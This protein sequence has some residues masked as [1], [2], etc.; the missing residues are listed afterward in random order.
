MMLEYPGSDS[1]E[2]DPTT[3]PGC[4]PMVRPQALVRADRLAWLMWDVADFNEQ[5]EFLSQFGMLTHHRDAQHLY[6]RAYG[7]A[8][9]V[10]IGRAAS[11][12]AFRGIGFCVNSREEL[13]CLAAGTGTDIES[14]DR[15]GG[16]EVVRLRDPH[17][18]DVEV[19]WGIEALPNM[20]TRRQP[21]PVNTVD[22]KARINQGQRP[23]LVPAPVLNIGH[24]VLGTDNFADSAQW[25]MRHLGLIPTDVT[26]LADGTPTI[27]FMRL[28]RGDKPADHHTIVISQ[29]LGT[30]YQHSAYEVADID[31]LGQGSQYLQMN[32]RKHSWGIGRHIMGSQLFDYWYDPQGYEFE[33]YAD[34]DVFTADH[35]TTYH[36]LDI[37]NIYAWGQDMPAAFYTPTLKQVL[38]IV[39]SLL[40]GKLSF[41]RL[42]LMLKATSRKPRPWL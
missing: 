27:A 38:G 17:G 21:L 9:C 4:K 16:G 36:P 5:E 42:K 23:P 8:P 28:D 33:H 41:A 35:A 31:A 39:G 15:P 34:G 2:I 22:N 30:G 10:F 1:F 24:C 26:C 40:T 37:G 20:S 29:A 25:Y 32:G 11:V 7:D 18:F 3:A 14:L 6:M 19:A 12:H 13:E